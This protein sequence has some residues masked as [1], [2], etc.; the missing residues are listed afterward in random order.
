[1][2]IGLVGKPNVGKS[3]FFSAAT[4]VDVQIANYPFTTINANVGV[5]YAIAEHPCR[6]LGCTPNPQNY[7][8]RD[9]KAL[10]PIK[11]IDVAG[12]VP[13]AHEGRGLG[14][15]FL[16]DLRMASALIHV[17]DATGK[18]DA[19]GQPTDH[20][21]PVE[22]IEFLEREIDY[23]IYGILRKNWEKFA[24]RIKLQHLKLAQAIADQLTGIG[25]TEE[26]AFEAIHKLGLDNDPTKWS[27][28]DLFAFVRELRKINKPIIIAANKADAAADAQIERL[29]RKGRSRGYIVIPTSAAAEL[30]LRKAAK[31]GFIDYVPGS[32]DFKI[33]K[34]MSGKQEK[35]LQLIKEK[36][37]D[38]FGSTGIQQVINT[39]VFE[40]LNLVPVYPVE[41]EHKLTDGFGNVLPHVHLLPKGSTPRDLAYKVHTD[42]GKTFLYAVNARTHRRVGDDYELEFNDI[43]KIVATAR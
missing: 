34:P 33:L 37:L 1:M 23:W 13:G 8:Y 26:D 21:D 41:D 24:K 30:T 40:L 39:A 19:E 38:R 27:D 32:S 17:V 3:T 42:L 7:E 12:L 6:E 22:D 35:A 15:K 14:N 20:H 18:T 10:I 31:A 29:V 43:I 5:T 16:D 9:G 25:V 2:E 28:E 11:M 36:V 4:L